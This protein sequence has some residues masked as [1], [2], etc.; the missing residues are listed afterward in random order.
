METPLKTLR[1]LCDKLG[2]SR[3]GGKNKVLKRLRMQ[4][5]TLEQRMTAEVARKMFLEQNREPDMPKVPVLPSARQQELHNVT[6][7]RPV[8]WDE[9]GR[10]HTRPSSQRSRRSVT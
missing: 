3:S 5:K 9:A 2:L 6:V 7:A 1:A 4:Q 8:S 10:A